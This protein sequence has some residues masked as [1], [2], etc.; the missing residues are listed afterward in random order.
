MRVKSMLVAAVLGVM[1]PGTRNEAEAAQKC[2][3]ECRPQVTELP[4]SEITTTIDDEIVSIERRYW[5]DG[6][7]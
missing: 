1:L 6:A 7:D 5:S 3:S 4:C 2:P